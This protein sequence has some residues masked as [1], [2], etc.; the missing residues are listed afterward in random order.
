[1][2]LTD[3]G[4]AGLKPDKTEFTVWDGRVA[5]LGVRVRPSGHRSFVWHG[6]GIVRLIRLDLKNLQSRPIRL[7]VDAT[8]PGRR[9]G[10]V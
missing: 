6:H 5:G 8:R 2:R 1:M 7:Q 4:I 10:L 9:L 3:A